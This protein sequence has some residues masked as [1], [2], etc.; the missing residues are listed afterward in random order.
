MS[1]YYSVVV[2]QCSSRVDCGTCFHESTT[3]LFVCVCA[4]ACGWAATHFLVLLLLSL[5]L[6]VCVFIHKQRVADTYLQ[7]VLKNSLI[8]PYDVS[9]TIRRQSGCLGK[10]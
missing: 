8:S 10:Y 1:R 2:L 3:C 6:S 4:C 5:S 7:E 9:Q